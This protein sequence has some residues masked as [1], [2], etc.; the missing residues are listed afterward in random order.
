MSAEIV[1]LD[2][3]LSTRYAS[4]ARVVAASL[5]ADAGFTVDEIDDLR[6]GLN[7]AVSLVADVEAD[8]DGEARLRVRFQIDD[9][10]VTVR[11]GRT[12][13]PA[14]GITIDVLAER[15][16]GAVVDDFSSDGDHFVLTKTAA[17]AAAG[18]R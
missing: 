16:L 17:G 10:R 1:E 13:V 11:V 18:Q 12:G 15:I 8:D 7:E 9:G 5:A 6:I 14:G 4:T 3:P 2:L